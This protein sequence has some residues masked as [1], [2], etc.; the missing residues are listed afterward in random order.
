MSVPPPYATATVMIADT[1][2]QTSFGLAPALRRGRR[3]STKTGTSVAE[4]IPPST[5]SSTMFGVVLATL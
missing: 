4:R 3:R 1:D 5:G 2:S